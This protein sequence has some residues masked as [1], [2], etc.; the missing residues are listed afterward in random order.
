MKNI[1]KQAGL[2]KAYTN[3]SIRA[4]AVTIL[5]KSG[6]EARHILAV[7]GHKNESSIRSYSKTDLSTKR[8]MS[9]TLST[10]CKVPGVVS[11]QQLSPILSLSREEIVIQNTHTNKSKTIHLY[12]CNV[13]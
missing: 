1:S 5:D 3:H 6:F 10:E 11:Q 2:T 13:M 8:K 12:N 9:E 4:T 7:S